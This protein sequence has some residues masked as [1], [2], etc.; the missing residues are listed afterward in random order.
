MIEEIA[1]RLEAGEAVKITGFGSFN[2]RDKGERLGRNP[3]TLEAAAIAPRRVVAFRASHVLKKRIDKGLSGTSDGQLGIC[4]P[5][6][7]KCAARSP[8]ARRTGT[9]DQATSG[10]IDESGLRKGELRKLRGA[11]KIP[12]HGDCRQGVRR[13][14][15]VALGW[16]G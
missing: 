14:A 8:T 13:V 12:G 16:V 10:E 4:E 9:M 3:H 11:S 1:A 7:Y 5:C 6:C 15:V 2:L